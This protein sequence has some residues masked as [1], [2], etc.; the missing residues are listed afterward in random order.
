MYCTASLRRYA[1]HLSYSA[2]GEGDVLNHFLSNSTSIPGT[3][4]ISVSHTHSFPFLP[5]PY[6]AYTVGSDVT[7]ANS[8]A[9]ES[10]LPALSSPLPHPH[11]S[12][13]VSAPRNAFS[14]LNGINGQLFHM[15]PILLQWLVCCTRH[16]NSLICSP[17]PHMHRHVTLRSLS[18]SLS[19]SLSLSLSLSLPPSLSLSLLLPFPLSPSLM[20][21]RNS[22]P[23]CPPSRATQGPYPSANQVTRGPL[24][25]C[26]SYSFRPLAPILNVTLIL[27]L[28]TSMKSI[29]FNLQCYLYSSLSPSASDSLL[30]LLHFASLLL[31]PRTL[32]SPPPFLSSYS[33]SSPQARTLP[34]SRPM[35]MTPTIPRRRSLQP[36]ISHSLLVSVDRTALLSSA[37][38]CSVL[39][40]SYTGNS[41]LL[42]CSS[43]S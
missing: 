29:D 16:S 37:L 11:P 12:N 42:Y 10:H 32:P 22:R 43:G 25:F 13:A 24:L 27:R 36:T 31:P 23:S 15:C 35:T 19:P 3:I 14:L 7:V 38:H 1:A 21:P 26:Y 4:L 5:F 28:T 18:H 30:F 17:F 6:R 8:I 40:A 33:L 9:D 34:P 20:I 39:S 41:Y 2:S